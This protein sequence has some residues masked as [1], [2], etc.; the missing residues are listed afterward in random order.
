MIINIV[1]GSTANKVSGK[2]LRILHCLFSEAE[3]KS[4][5]QHLSEPRTGNDGVYDGGQVPGEG[6]TAS[7]VGS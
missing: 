2:L 5:R 3:V 6:I 1:N 4:Y 7:T